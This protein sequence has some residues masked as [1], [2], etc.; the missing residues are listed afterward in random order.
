MGAAQDS[1]PGDP[2]EGLEG[3]RRNFPLGEASGL[4]FAAVRKSAP[5]VGLAWL[6]VAGRP[7]APADE[8]LRPA[9]TSRTAVLTWL[10]SPMV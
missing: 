8:A 7:R 9:L 5:V 10:Q 3:P 4:W 6:S 2:Q 1:L